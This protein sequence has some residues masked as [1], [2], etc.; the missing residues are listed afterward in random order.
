MQ[1]HFNCSEEE[2]EDL[3]D[4]F[5]GKD[6]TSTEMKYSSHWHPLLMYTSIM[7][8]YIAE[9][10]E[11][12]K[13]LCTPSKESQNC[14][15][16]RYTIGK[17]TSV[18]PYHP[19]GVYKPNYEESCLDEFNMPV[20]EY[21]QHCVMVTVNMTTQPK[22]LLTR[23]RSIKDMEFL[24]NST[25][26]KCKVNE[27]AKINDVTLNC[28]E[29]GAIC[30]EK[31]KYA[32]RTFCSMHSDRAISIRMHFSDQTY[33]SLLDNNRVRDFKVSILQSIAE[34]LQISVQH[35]VNATLTIFKGAFLDFTVCPPPSINEDEFGNLIDKT[36]QFLITGSFTHIFKGATEFPVASSSIVIEPEIAVSFSDYEGFRMLQVIPIICGIFVV[37]SFIA[38]VVRLLMSQKQ[39]PKRES[40]ELEDFSESNFAQN[41][42]QKLTV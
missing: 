5:Q 6:D 20:K 7:T 26:G 8:S 29:E 12:S 13:H 4:N 15:V 2:F 11:D 3:L 21:N 14:D 33:E 34:N 22:C 40:V 28:P 16:M 35:I 17:C 39:R 31:E 38:S 36:Q 1:N 23:C 32:N 30:Y 42:N 41:S 24:I 18:V 25:W 27:M 9:N 10:C 19:C 37:A